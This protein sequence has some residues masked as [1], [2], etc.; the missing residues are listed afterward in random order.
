MYMHRPT[1]RGFTL[2]ELTIVLVIVSLLLGGLLLPLSAQQ[3]I[4]QQAEAD[5]QLAEARDALVGFAQINGRLPCPASNAVGNGKEDCAGAVYGFLPWGE[6]GVRPTDP[7]GHL[8]RYRVSTDF[9]TLV[10]PVGTSTTAELKIQ[11]RQG[12]ALT[13][14][15]NEAPRDVAFVIVSH[16]KNGYY[17]TNTDASA[18]PPDPV[19]INNPDEDSNAATLANVGSTIFVSRTPTHEDAPTIGGFDDLVVWMPRSLLINRL[20]AAGRI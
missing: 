15:T 20:V 9:K 11:T 6:I 5:K 16:G 8:I 18:G 10:P 1:S 19:G 4:R 3:D 2:V 14:L 12:T 7:W 17:G 13:D